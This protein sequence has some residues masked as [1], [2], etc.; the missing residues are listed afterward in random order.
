[1]AGI[2]INFWSQLKCFVYAKSLQSCLTLCD[3]MNYKPTRLLCPSG[4]S[5]QEYWSR[6]PRCPPGDL[7]NRGIE[8]T[9]PALAGRFFTT[10][11]P[12]KCCNILLLIILMFKGFWQ[13]PSLPFVKSF[14][15]RKLL[16]FNKCF[17]IS[18]GDQMM[19]SFL[20][21]ELYF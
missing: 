9:S 5:R 12:R 20:C 4:F 10:A 15:C 21:S 2:F 13:I 16:N 7:P 14:D 8:P 11:P 1:M 18:V 6:L 3:L 19:F 17:S